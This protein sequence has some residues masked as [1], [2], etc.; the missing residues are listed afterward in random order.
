MQLS[1]H[2][3]LFCRFA[4]PNLFMKCPLFFKEHEIFLFFVFILGAY[5]LFYVGGSINNVG[6]HY[7]F[8][9]VIEF[10]RTIIITDSK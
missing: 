5:R 1:L 6:K 2:G 9:A 8:S 10:I 7:I 4:S 3:T